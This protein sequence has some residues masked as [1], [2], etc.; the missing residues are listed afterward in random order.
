MACYWECSNR[1]AA[2]ALSAKSTQPEFFA[3]RVLLALQ[4]A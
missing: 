4:P 2:I 1:Y 3:N